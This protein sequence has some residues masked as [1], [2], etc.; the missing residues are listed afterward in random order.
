MVCAQVGLYGLYACPIRGCLAYS[1]TALELQE[2]ARNR[3]EA[4]S[5]GVEDVKVG[6]ELIRV[7]FIPI[8]GLQGVEPA[9]AQHG[10]QRH[11]A[12]RAVRGTEADVHCYRRAEGRELRDDGDGGLLR[13]LGLAVNVRTQRVVCWR[14]VL[15]IGAKHPERHLDSY[16]LLWW[17]GLAR[18]KSE[19]IRL[20]N[21]ALHSLLS[22]LEVP[23]HDA[24]LPDAELLAGHR[25]AG[26]PLPY[27]GH[28]IWLDAV[29]CTEC[30]YVAITS[31]AFRNHRPLGSA[32]EH[33]APA[34]ERQRPCTAQMLSTGFSRLAIEVS[35]A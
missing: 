32:V 18:R 24:V 35:V 9:R 10:Q 26:P 25:A 14:C 2:H 3:C 20:V 31:S 11:V 30:A 16:H 33:R 1:M 12:K 5:D 27:E 23:L 13:R 22:R 29:Q 28:G 15:I 7:H 19:A 6:S 17:E 4:L 21:E 34:T 8:W